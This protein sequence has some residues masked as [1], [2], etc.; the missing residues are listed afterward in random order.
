MSKYVDYR[1]SICDKTK[2]YEVGSVVSCCP[3]ADL[4]VSGEAYDKKPLT[5]KLKG[6]ADAESIRPERND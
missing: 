4:T 6:D 1:C 3:G 5:K 2:S